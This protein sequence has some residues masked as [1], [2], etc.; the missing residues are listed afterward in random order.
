[1]ITK[2]R[3]GDFIETKAGL[4][5]DVKGLV[6]PPNRVIAFPRYVP[7]KEGSRRRDGMTYDKVYSLAARYNLLRQQYPQYLVNDRVFDETICEVPIRDILKLYKPTRKLQELRLFRKRNA[8]EDRAFKF[9]RIV[10][11]RSKIRWDALGLSGSI[12][13]QLHKASSDIDLVV[14]G[15]ENCRKV[16]SALQTMIE[17]HEIIKPYRKVELKA[18]FDFR[19]KDTAVTFEDFVR[20]ESRKVMQ[21]TFSGT[22]YF[23]RFVKNWGE[24][25]KK[26]GDVLYENLGDAK[27]EATVVDDSESIF[28]PCV[29]EINCTKVTEGNKNWRPNQIASFR[30]RFCEQAKKGES[31]IA[32]GKVENVTDKKRGTQHCRLLI[33]NNPSDFIILK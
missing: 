26:Y 32:R 27:I 30:G 9:A 12:L 28:T 8:L 17:E 31:V 14:Y 23:F 15:S 19:S 22:D 2:A 33:G 13:V 6:H 7:D 20:T 5:F 24:I 21:G 25:G 4:L 1:L 16:H 11:E 3:E 10:K 29:Y 18:L